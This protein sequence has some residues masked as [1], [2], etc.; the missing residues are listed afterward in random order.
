MVALSIVVVVLRTAS[1]GIF[2]PFAM[3]DGI[4]DKLFTYKES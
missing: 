2:V 3:I 1:A 4:F